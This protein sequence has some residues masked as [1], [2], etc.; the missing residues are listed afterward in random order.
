MQVL[1]TGG[2]GFIGSHLVRR[3]TAEGFQVTVLDNLSSGNLGNLSCFSEKVNFVEGD[4][5]NPDVV[6]ESANGAEAIVHLAALIDVAESIKKPRL[7]VDVNVSGTLNVLEAAKKAEVF[8]FASSAAVYGE[9]LSLPI[10]ELHPLA[11]LSPYGAT[12]VAG[13]ALVQ[14]YARIRGFRPVILRI[15]NVY[16]PKQSKAYAD[17]V[18]EFTK[19]VLKDEPPIIYGDGEQ[20]RDFIYVDDVV[21]CL[22]AAI[23]NR[24]A[25]GVYNVGSGKAVSI[26]ELART[27]AEVL[28]KPNLKPVYAP[29]RPGDVKHS[30]ASISR[31]REC[32]GYTPRFSLEQGLRK[33]SEY[34]LE[35]AGKGL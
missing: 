30:V 13:E 29:A 23:K 34:L 4:V 35:L 17:V 6:E 14:A 18:L 31:L 15:F 5:R 8:V 3:L 20:T 19:R 26:G 27:V 9:P 22:V 24:H 21:E 28:G 11:P 12:K 1:V 16:G 33:L 25:C 2:A 10:E 7:Y 32:L